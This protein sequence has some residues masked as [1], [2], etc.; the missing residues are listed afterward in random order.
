LALELTPLAASELR[1]LASP[2]CI[3]LAMSILKKQST[4]G[5]GKFDARVLRQH[6]TTD[7]LRGEGWLLAYEAGRRCWLGNSDNKY[8]MADKYFR[9][10]LMR[11]VSFFDE[12]A[13]LPAIF[14][15]KQPDTFDPSLFESDVDV[16][17]FF[18]FDEA[19][20]EY[21]DKGSED[22]DDEHEAGGESTPDS[23]AAKDPFGVEF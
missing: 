7:A 20:E 13:R 17:S 3:V 1:S 10:L 9:E 2:T 12:S 6:A 18:E 21:F 8:I 5:R 23:D 19:D 11:E 22:D 14:S 4:A 16:D 15:P